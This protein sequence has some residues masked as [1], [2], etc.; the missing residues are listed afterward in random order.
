MNGVKHSRTIFNRM[1]QS[2]TS[3]MNPAGSTTSIHQSESAVLLEVSMT[4]AERV[5][6][7]LLNFF[8]TFHSELT[9]SP[10]TRNECFD[11]PFLRVVWTSLTGVIF[12]QKAPKENKCRTVR[13]ISHSRRQSLMKDVK[14]VSN[15]PMWFIWFSIDHKTGRRFRWPGNRFT[16]VVSKKTRT[17]QNTALPSSTNDTIIIAFAS[18]PTFFFPPEGINQSS[19]VLFINSIQGQ[20]SIDRWSK[21]D[22]RQ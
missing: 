21:L 11:M 22:D 18:T 3:K 12:R 2:I 6:G 15:A 19:Q 13:V 17:S 9:D 4:A 1:N 20:S 7:V 16:V 10:F 8:I 5:R 14:T